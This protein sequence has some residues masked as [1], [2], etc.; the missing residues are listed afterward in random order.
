MYIAKGIAELHEGHLKVASKGHGYGTTFT[1][2]LPLH[3]VPDSEIPEQL[4]KRQRLEFGPSGR[5][6]TASSDELVMEKLRL[7]VVDDTRL[8]LR[9]LVRLLE[10]RGHTCDQAEDGR[11]AVQM[12]RKCLDAGIPYDSVL[13]D[14]E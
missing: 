9:L 2:V 1:M 4:R 11:E 7:L 14:Y 8:N 6:R 5:G 13:M 12:V 3:Q 10:K